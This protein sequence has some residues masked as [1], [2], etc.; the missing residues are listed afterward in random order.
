MPQ[1]LKKVMGGQD[2]KAARPSEVPLDQRAQDLVN[3]GDKM[4][5]VEDYPGAEEAY[6]SAL[7]MDGHNAAAWQRRGRI[8]SH[9]GK[10]TEAM[11]CHVRA[12][13]L[14]GRQSRAWL[15]LGEAILSFVKADLEPLFI[16][17]NRAE[18]MG[19]ALDCFQRALKFDAGLAP[20]R[21][22]LEACRATIGS[23]P[24]KMANPRIFSFHSRGLLEKAK[25]EVVSPFLKPGDY[26]RKPTPLPMDD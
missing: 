15:G 5:S 2:A 13:E 12:L 23:T 24:V 10:I 7:T 1:W 26:R 20:A 18:I 6:N 3:L 17:E 21:Q 22:G 9:Q 11:A 19:E 16:R 8:F 14:D 25:R 4:F